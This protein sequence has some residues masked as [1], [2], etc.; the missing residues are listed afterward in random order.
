[1]RSEGLSRSILDAMNDIEDAYIESARKRLQDVRRDKKISED[2]IIRGDKKIRTARLSLL[3]KAAVLFGVLA[4][5]AS[6][7]VA[8]AMAVNEEFREAVKEVIYE[9]FHIEEA[10]MI[11]QMPVESQ[12]TVENMYVEQDRSILGDVIEGRYIHAPVFCHAREGIFT[13]CTDEI[14]LNQGSHYDAYYE[15]NGEFIQLEEHRF[16]ANYNV[17]GQAFD[18]S[19]EWAVHNGQVA[20]TYIEEEERFRIPANPGDAEAMLL[21]VLTFFED[22]NGQIMENAYPLQVNLYTGEVTDILAGTGAEKLSGICNYAISE[23]RSRMLLA[24]TDGELYYVD[25]TEK[26]LYS[27]SELS[28]EKPDSCS[29]IED[30]LTC[31]AEGETGYCGWNI[32]LTNFERKELF[33]DLQKAA[34]GKAGLLSLSGFSGARHWGSMY[35]GACFALT[36]DAV[37]TVS[38]LDLK[39]GE[40][41][42]VEGFQ[43][44]GDQYQDVLWEINPDGRRILISGGQLGS[45]YEY[46]GVL[47][48]EKQTYLEFSRENMNPVHEKKPYWFDKDTVIIPAI[49]QNSYLAQDYYVYDLLGED[50]IIL[51][52]MA[53]KVDTWL[54]E[55][56]NYTIRIPQEGW[57]MTEPGQWSAEANDRVRLEIRDFSELGKEEVCA[58]L[59]EEGY[60]VSEEDDAFYN[61]EDGEHVVKNVRLF[62][63]DEKLIGVFYQYPAEAVEG[64]GGRLERIVGTF[65]F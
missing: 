47:D 32:N 49:Q 37:G 51:E 17:L 28:G 42:P 59:S 5:A 30:T 63:T 23:D 1:M 65:C 53:E 50:H 60:A 3:Q 27:V 55:G 35:S 39:T 24:E 58:V 45:G 44:P 56:V 4:F 19:F 15:E 61:Y 10:E 2:K 43:W 25:L 6:T 57:Q 21:E 31:W 11:P 33:S 62:E 54:Y 29:L 46:I 20:V 16:Q 18:I 41:I 26:R 13:I 12:I 34:S 38:V 48:F 40:E 36:K 8:T 52:G 7:S 9:I 14:E 64:F 22:E